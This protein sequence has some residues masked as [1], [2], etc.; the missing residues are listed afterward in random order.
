MAKN[1]ITQEWRLSRIRSQEN[2]MRV[3]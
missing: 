3:V 1:S 2:K